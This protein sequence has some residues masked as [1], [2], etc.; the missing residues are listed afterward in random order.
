M[1][2][3]SKDN[4]NP[5][6]TTETEMTTTAVDYDSGA[7]E[8]SS[9]VDFSTVDVPL[10]EGDY[11][12]TF[13][14]FKKGVVENGPNAGTDMYN[15]RFTINGGDFDGENRFR[16]Y[17]LSRKALRFFKMDMISLGAPTDVWGGVLNVSALLQSLQGR[18]C[19]LE[20]K[21][22]EYEDRDTGQMVT[23]DDIKRIKDKS[24]NA[25]FR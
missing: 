6:T 12:A 8:T 13:V 24:A 17:V 11:E 15:L 5:T 4:D 10:P 18:T 19:V 21:H 7:D 23:T 14:D 1:P 25:L 20:I 16:R 3:R 9:L 2:K 22:R